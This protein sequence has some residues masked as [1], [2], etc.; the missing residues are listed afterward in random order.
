MFKFFERKSGWTTQ[1]LTKKKKKKKPK[2]GISKNSISFLKKDK[3][4][5]GVMVAKLIDCIG[6]FF[7]TSYEC[8]WVFLLIPISISPANLTF[9]FS[10]KINGT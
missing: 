10:S 2:R 7:T 1:I 8:Q 6:H 3:Q 9:E 5:F 4:T